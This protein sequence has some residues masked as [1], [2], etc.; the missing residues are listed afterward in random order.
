M[1][2]EGPIPA[3][4]PAED[5]ASA[6][7]QWLVENHS[8]DAG[9]VRILADHETVV[10]YW[11]GDPPADLQ[12]I[13]AAQPVPVTIRKATYSRD[14]LVAAAKEL[15]DANRGVITAAG[16]NHDLSAVWITFS[17]KAPQT[18]LAAVRTQSAVPVESGGVL[19]IKSTS[20]RA[21]TQGEYPPSQG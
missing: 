2:F 15:I 19:D 16:P 14:E 3:S 12:Q 9:K 20:G 1:D 7:T 4:T 10:V 6:V 17:S 8:P 5:A 21:T 18:A 13:V 11:K